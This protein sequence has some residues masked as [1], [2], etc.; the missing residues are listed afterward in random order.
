M[1][2]EWEQGY[3]PGLK[4]IPGLK[5]RSLVNLSCVRSADASFLPNPGKLWDP[6]TLAL[7]DVVKLTGN[8]QVSGQDSQNCPLPLICPEI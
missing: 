3:V 8:L 5:E 7:S 6:H 1:C 4:D 2:S